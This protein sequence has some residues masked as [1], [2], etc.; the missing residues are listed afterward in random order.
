VWGEKMILKCEGEVVSLKDA[1]MFLNLNLNDTKKYVYKN[2][3]D[4]SLNG[5]KVDVILPIIDETKKTL[6]NN[7]EYSK[8]N[9]R[10]YNYVWDG[11]EMH[12]NKN[13]VEISSITKKT[14]VAVITAKNRAI[15]YG[16][17]YFVIGTYI[18]SESDY[19][20][21]E[22]E[23]RV[24]GYSNNRFYFGSLTSI[25]KRIKFKKHYGGISKALNKSSEYR[26]GESKIWKNQ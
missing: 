2:K 23:I 17:N 21:R 10:Y 13:A 20:G 26:E 5:F 9:P 6:K 24:G 14:R 3:D 4:F 1:S 11:K 15:S 25:S 19:R 7:R 18:V 16:E 12:Y 22:H 8:H